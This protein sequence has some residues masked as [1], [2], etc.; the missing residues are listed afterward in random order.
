MCYTR[1]KP[2]AYM[3]A[4]MP[5]RYAFIVTFNPMVGQV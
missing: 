2:V 4:K 5:K 3:P 1:R